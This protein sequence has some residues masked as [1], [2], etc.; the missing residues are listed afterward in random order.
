[1]P[2]SNKRSKDYFDQN[3]PW[4]QCPRAPTYHSGQKG[5]PARSKPERYH[6]ALAEAAKRLLAADLW[7]C[8][9]QLAPLFFFDLAPSSR[10]RGWWFSFD[11]APPVVA[12]QAWLAG[13][14]T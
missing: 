2:D 9:P 6:D 10:V 11:L 14:W 5:Q 13:G 7:L 12:G 1:V 3:E 8:Q 4:Y